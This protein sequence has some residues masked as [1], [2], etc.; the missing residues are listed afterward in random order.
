MQL[1]DAHIA[2]LN[3]IIVEWD[4]AEVDIKKAEQVCNNVVIPSIKELRYAGRRIVDVITKMAA[5]ASQEDIDDLLADAKFDCHRARHDAIDAAT[6]K[7]A[8]DLEIMVTK[9][10]YEVILPVHPQFPQLVQE[11]QAV[12]D[13]IAAS[14][15]DR[16][17]REAIYSVIEASDFPDL[18]KSYETMMASEYIMVSIA[19]KRRRS[20]VW[21]I[22]GTVL[23]AIGLGAAFLFWK[24]P[25]VP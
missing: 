8:I 19:K 21:G 16:E 1:S 12:R 3:S 6:S 25:V 22:V 17:N 13:K 14:R 23:G 11:L 18:I 10:G 4:R 15:K 7:I 9:L 20:E 5:G 2:L 24:F